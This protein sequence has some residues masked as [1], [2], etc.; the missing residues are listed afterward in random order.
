MN[1]APPRR[2]PVSVE[3][4]RDGLKDRYARL[5]LV[6]HERHLAQLDLA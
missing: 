2:Q 1:K 6:A 5:A 3:A 4:A